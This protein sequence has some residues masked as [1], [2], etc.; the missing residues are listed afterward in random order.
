VDRNIG[1]HGMNE[2]MFGLRLV[3]GMGFLVY[4]A[5]RI[6]SDSPIPASLPARCVCV[7]AVMTVAFGAAWR[8]KHVLIPADSGPTSETTKR[9]VIV[10]AVAA[11]VILSGKASLVF[12]ACGIFAFP[13]FIALEIQNARSGGELFRAT[14][15]R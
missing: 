4:S 3:V 6:I 13:M 11:S 7:A 1:A 9:A 15:D 8:W 2:R 10:I 14:L 5:V 12:A